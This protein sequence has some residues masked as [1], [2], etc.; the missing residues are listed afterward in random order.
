[1]GVISLQMEM[2]VE[3]MQKIFGAGD[4]Y[5]KKLEKDLQV[6]IV[7][8][9]GKIIITGE[10]SHANQACRILSQLTEFSKRGNEIE[11]QS[12]DYAITLGMENQEEILD[13]LT[14]MLWEMAEQQLINNRRSSEES[15]RIDRFNRIITH[16]EAFINRVFGL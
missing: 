16:P 2:T 8:R 10:E 14:D 6:T 4:S 11:E 7:D 9:N 3:H 15:D 12:V 5:I 13:N 1:M